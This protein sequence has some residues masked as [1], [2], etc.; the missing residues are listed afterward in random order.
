[1]NIDD[2][3]NSLNKNIDRIS[4]SDA[5]HIIDLTIKNYAIYNTY[6]VELQDTLLKNE[7]KLDPKLNALNFFVMHSTFMF[8]S[9][10]NDLISNNYFSLK[11][12]IRVIN[13]F[14]FK[15]L[16][17]LYSDNYVSEVYLDFN[18]VYLYNLSRKFDNI[19]KLPKNE[20]L[21]LK[22]NYKKIL[23]KYN[24]K[25]DVK[26][27]Y[28]IKLAL[29]HNKKQKSGKSIQEIIEWLKSNNKIENAI[30]IA[31]EDN[32]DFNHCG[33]GSLNYQQLV[34]LYDTQNKFYEMYQPILSEFN[35][36]LVKLVVRFMDEY[37]EFKNQ[38][39]IDVLLNNMH[40]IFK[41]GSDYDV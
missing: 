3:S 25:G 7:N 37:P 26:E 13:E 6:F 22:N 15:Y 34:D 38:E 30:I 9:F 32:C 18:D 16:F 36:M 12:N 11:I 31:Y 14:Y 23:K 19:L 28:W 39:V 29:K 40:T 2:Y 8:N 24:I 1:M 17:L 4:K 27:D 21:K 35:Y 20:I 33:I 10:I 5:K 41:R